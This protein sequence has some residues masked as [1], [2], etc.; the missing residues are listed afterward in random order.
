[1]SISTTPYTHNS[2]SELNLDPESIELADYFKLEERVEESLSILRKKARENTHRKLVD[3]NVKK[4]IGQ[5]NDL[6]VNTSGS[7]ESK[8]EDE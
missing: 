7:K 4:L 5:S 2:G 1:M 8:E 3:E 6:S